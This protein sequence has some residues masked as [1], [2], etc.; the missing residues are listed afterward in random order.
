MA[1][2]AKAESGAIGPGGIEWHIEQRRAGDLKEWER[3]PRRITD[4]QAKHLA[5][6]VIKFGYVEPIV[7]NVDGTIIGGHQ[8]HRIMMQAN[9]INYET[10]LP[11]LVPSRPLDEEEHE[12]LAIRLNKNVGT[13]DFDRLTSE[14]DQSSLRD[15]GFSPMDFGMI[16]TDSKVEPEKLEPE[17]LTPA[18]LKPAKPKT[19]THC[20]QPCH[21]VVEK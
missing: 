18:S 2:K 14:F 8:R 17:P 1:K 20:E 15:W 3:N 5:T 21:C 12:E 10:I 7:V 6:S 9:L 4:S 19:C 13:W 11:V 16:S